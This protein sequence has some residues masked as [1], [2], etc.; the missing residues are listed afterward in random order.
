MG[1]LVGA[2]VFENGVGGGAEAGEAS[3]AEAEVDGVLLG[4]EAGEEGV[5]VVGA[6]PRTFVLAC[7]RPASTMLVERSISICSFH[8]FS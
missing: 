1:A 3:G 7:R 2:P 5:V 4:G 6:G 8:S